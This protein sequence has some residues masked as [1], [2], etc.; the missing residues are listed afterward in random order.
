MKYS[1]EDLIKQDS[2]RE[3]EALYWEAVL[4]I[5]FDMDSAGDRD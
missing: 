2:E 4:D 1:L 3:L 5:I